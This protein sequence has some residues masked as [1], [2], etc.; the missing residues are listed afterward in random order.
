MA[1]KAGLANKIKT[2][3][4][5]SQFSD[6]LTKDPQSWQV[7]IIGFAIDPDA[8]PYYDTLQAELP[9]YPIT[10][11]EVKA[12]TDPQINDFIQ[13]ITESE[14]VSSGWFATPCGD[15]DITGMLELEI[16]PFFEKAGAW[17]RDIVDLN[18]ATR[19]DLAKQKEL[20]NAA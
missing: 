5:V 14:Y 12:I 20:N 15:A 19:A 7:M 3:Q 18:I 8:G 11:A 13:T 2:A 17:N 1:S 9:D 4:L 16:I 6:R 10:S